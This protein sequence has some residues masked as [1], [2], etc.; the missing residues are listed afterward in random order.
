MTENTEFQGIVE[1]FEPSMRDQSTIVLNHRK[2]EF[3]K[4]A[5]ALMMLTWLL[6]IIP[7]VVIAWKV[8]L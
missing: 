2:A 3:W 5:N 8:A 4:H 6:L 1:Q 7:T